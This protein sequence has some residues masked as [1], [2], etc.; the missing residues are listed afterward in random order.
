MDA[1]FG[2]NDMKFHVFTLMGFDNHLTCVPKVWII[3]SRQI[4]ENLI[5]WW[6]PS[7]HKML[8]HMPHSKPSCFFIDHAP[9]ELKALWLVLYLI[10]MLYL[11]PW[12]FFCIFHN[13]APPNS[14]V[15]STASQN[16]KTT[17]G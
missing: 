10:P 16:V 13:D 11:F 4:V 14:L 3:T 5:E 2:T 9:Q 7:K 12:M 15:D 17:D 8:S 1:T 6:K